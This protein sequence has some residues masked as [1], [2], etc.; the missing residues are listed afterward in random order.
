M[1]ILYACLVNKKRTIVT[2][3][4]ATR[5]KGDFSSEIL[6]NYDNFERYGKKFIVLSAE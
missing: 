4:F 6:N 2:E 3:C 1:P 5:L